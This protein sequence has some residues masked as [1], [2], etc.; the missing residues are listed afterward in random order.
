MAHLGRVGS[1]PTPGAKSYIKNEQA[2]RV[3]IKIEKE[4]IVYCP[5][6][7]DGVPVLV[8]WGKERNGC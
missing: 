3:K 5:A 4:K 1:N 6:T 2:E 8:D 7:I